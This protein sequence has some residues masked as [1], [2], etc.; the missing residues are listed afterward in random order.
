MITCLAHSTL[1]S[2]HKSPKILAKQTH[3]FFSHRT[4]PHSDIPRS[5]LTLLPRIKLRSVCFF[6]AGKDENTESEFPV[7]KKWDVPW[8]WPT[9]SLTF[10]A[11]A[12]S[13][14]LTGLAER[15][16]LPYLGIKIE[17]LTLDEK[18][19]TLFMDQ[20]ITTAVILG[21]LYSV[22]NTFQPLPED[23]YRYD[24]REP[25]SM[26][27]GWLL[28][29]LF[30]LVGATIAIGLTGAAMSLF[31][32]EDPQRETDALVRLLP[33][34]GS[35]GISTACLLGITGVLA[36]V[37][38]ET[39]FRGFLMVSLTKWVP[40]PVSIIISAAAFA[41]AHLT[42]GEFPQLFILGAVLGLSYAQ[43]RNLMTPITIHAFWNSAV[44]LLLTFIQLQG[45]DLK[46]LLGAS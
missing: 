12:L 33:L 45:Y 4:Y 15:A 17:E 5:R 36:P 41:L 8:G 11:C 10:L 18:A 16:T 40:T 29:A 42:P 46:D 39:V 3:P 19:E 6:N 1:Y 38:E 35:S 22:A 26:K 37:L 20:S 14:V 27:K 28:W 31:R 43:T 13:F 21:I 2:L 24:L 30:G 7:L 32:G 44:I 23:I 9:V 34:I 25:F